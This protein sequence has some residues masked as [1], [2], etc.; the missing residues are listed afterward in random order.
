[1]PVS[2]DARDAVVGVMGFQVHGHF[3]WLLW[4]AVHLYKYKLV[5]LK[6]QFQV[7]LDRS[8]PLFS[9]DAAII[10]RPRGC[11]LCEIASEGDVSSI[12]LPPRSRPRLYVPVFVLSV[13]VELRE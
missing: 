13:E 12:A 6:K 5:S 8:L 9:R 2:L 4:N 3:A 10:R 1:M 7:T 11:K